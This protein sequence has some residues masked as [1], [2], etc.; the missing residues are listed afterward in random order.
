[1]YFFRD[2]HDTTA[3][4]ALRAGGYLICPPLFV[5][6]VLMVVEAMLTATTTWLVINA[7]RKFA[8]HQF[9]ASDL[10]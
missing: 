10:S 3:D 2:P 4:F 9:A 8:N 7:G 6:V 5:M 1:L